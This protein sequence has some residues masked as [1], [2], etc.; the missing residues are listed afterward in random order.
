MAS[1][2]VEDFLKNVY[3]LQSV[4]LPASSSVLARRLQ[5]SNA[6]VTDMSRKLADQGFII[7]RKYRAIQMTP[8]GERIALDV[9]RRHRLWELFLNKI[10][11]IPW[12]KVHDEAELLEHQTSE[13]LIN[14]IDSFLGFPKVDPHGDPIP[15]QTGFIAN[16][17]Y[18]KMSDL[19]SPAK[20]IVKRILDHDGKTFRFVNEVGISLNM[21]LD[22]VENRPKENSVIVEI[23]GRIVAIAMEFARNIFVE[24]IE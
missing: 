14:K 16:S 23:E 6:A 2:S 1:I 4:G 10:L 5:V 7:Y 9:V 21:E 15:D 18:S 24:N 19:K 3:A 8:E 20:L 17:N 22:F 12:E 11:D 13:Y